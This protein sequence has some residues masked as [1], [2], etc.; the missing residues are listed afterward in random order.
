MAASDDHADKEQTDTVSIQVV[1]EL[2]DIM[3]EIKSDM[4]EMKSEIMSKLSESQKDIQEMRDEMKTLKT[5]VTLV[6]T[7]T[8]VHAERLDDIENNKLKQLEQESD[9]KIHYLEE[10][11]QRLEIHD[12]KQNL[13]FYNI[14]ERSGE[15]IQDV[16]WNVFTQNY[17]LTAEQINNIA[18]QNVHRLPQSRHARPVNGKLPHRP[19]I[20]RFLYLSDRNLFADTK[21][22]RQG[23][24]LRVLEDL[25]PEMKQERGRLSGIAYRLR[26]EDR[27]MTRI[28]VVKTQVHLEYKSRNAP[29]NAWKLYTDNKTHKT[30]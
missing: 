29:Y 26:T 7:A 18:I 4:K 10:K 27:V 22:L 8:G 25:P 3:R 30:P 20:V 2:R 15:V 5:T 6:E 11:I 9:K 16:M 13:I 19:V 21:N 28:R 1:N 17:A 23:S 12:R 14:E 24:K